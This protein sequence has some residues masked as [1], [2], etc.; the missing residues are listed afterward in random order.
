[1]LKLNSKRRSDDLRTRLLRAFVI[2]AVA[3]ASAACDDDSPTGPIAQTRVDARVQ[4]ST[5][6][7]TVTGTFAGNFQASMWDGDRWVDLGSP[8]GITVGLQSGASVTVHGEQSVPSGSYSRVRLILQGVS[9]LVA[10]GS[11]VGGTTLTNSAT[12]A[13]G[14]S[15]Q[16]VEL[17]VSV[18]SFSVGDDPTAERII[19]FDLH[20]SQWLTSS[21]VQSG[22]VDDAALRASITASTHEGVS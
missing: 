4:D 17:V 5:G 7:S 21:V 16:R 8:N 14:G 18:S 1:M 10:A 20:S 22:Q 13:L 3:L 15:D 2:V 6:S 9:V 12:V 11:R 19:V